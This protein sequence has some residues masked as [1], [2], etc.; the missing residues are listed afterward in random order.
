MLQVNQLIFKV[1]G[2]QQVI[3]KPDL[4]VD[5]T[6][7]NLNSLSTDSIFSIINLTATSGTIFNNLNPFSTNAT[8]SINNINF[9][10]TSFGSI[11]KKTT[12]IRVTV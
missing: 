10:S 4:T 3:N 2:I 11:L 6:H 9:T 7:T 1:I 8:L 5:A 12:R